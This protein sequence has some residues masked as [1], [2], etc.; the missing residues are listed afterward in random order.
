MLNDVM[1]QQTIHGYSVHV[2]CASN[3]YSIDIL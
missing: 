3:Q 1:E 2:Y